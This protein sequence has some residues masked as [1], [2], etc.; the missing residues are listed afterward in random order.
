MEERLRLIVDA[1]TN[2]AEASFG[3]LTSSAEKTA[4]AA[5]AAAASVASAADRVAQAR[6]RE[7]D[8]AGKLAIAEAKLD[9][10]RSRYGE[11]S[12]QLVAAEERVASAQRGVQLAAANTAQ[13]LEAQQTAQESATAAAEGGAEASDAAGGGAERF[14]EEVDGLKESVVGLV[15]GVSL[16]DWLSESVSGYLEGARAAS[17][18]AM[19]MNATTEEG[20]RFIAVA[21]QLGLEMG[22]LLEIQASFA[23]VVD[24]TPELLASFGAEVKT[25]A[26]GTTNWALTLQDALG[27]LQEIPDATQRNALGF[28]LFGEEGYKQMSRLLLSGKSVDEV[29][30]AMG[31]PFTDEDVAATAEFESA[32]S[33]LSSTGGGLSREVGAVLVP[34]LTAALNVFGAVADVVT[35]I[36]GPMGVAVVAAIA[37]AIANRLTA[38]SGGLLAATST[39][40]SGALGRMAG[41]SMV[42][43]GSTTALGIAGGA[44][45]LA[46]GGLVTMLGGP[47]GVALIALG[48]GF[49]LLNSTMGDS[50][51]ESEDAAAAQD[52]L[53]SALEESGGVVTANVRQKAALSAQES[54]LLETAKAAGVAQGDVTDALLGNEDALGRVRSAL[55]AYRTENSR[56]N[57][58]G[59]TQLNAQ[60]QAA[61]D[62]LGSLTS[63][64]EGTKET[65][66]QQ[67]ELAGELEESTDKTALAQAAMDAL[68]GALDGGNVS[69]A[70]LARLTGEAARAQDEESAASDRAKAALDAYNATTRDAVDATLER[71]NAMYSAEDANFRFLDAMDEANKATDDGTTSVNEQREA[72]VKLIQAVLSAAGSVAD[73][74][75]EG[76]EAAGQVLTD[77][78]R[79]NVRATAMIQDLRNKMNTPG[80]S[81]GAREEIQALIDQLTTAQ[82][83]GDV[84]A[85]LTLTGA[86]EAQHQIDETTKDQTATVTVESRGGP[87]VNEYLATITN[88]TRLAI[89]RVESRNGPAVAEY[90]GGL[91]TA[92]RLSLIRVESRNGPAVR[93]YLDGLAAERLSIIRVETRGGPAVAAYLDRLAGDR[94]ARINVSHGAGATYGAP[95]LA[96][97]QLGRVAVGSVTLDLELTGRA[98]RGQLTKAERG[99]ARVEEIRA[100]ERESGRGWRQ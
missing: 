12:S 56:E 18:L 60:G 24:A 39:A 74:A 11:G 20:G 97:A 49:A 27:R 3:K 73:A 67:G 7:A 26:D 55:E 75:I 99:R 70:D 37:L 15:A 53:T 86:P 92:D 65:A 96:G 88:A 68:T 72:Q 21:S 32:M 64:A 23:Q 62:A 66:D 85:V 42:A 1:T 52:A 79:A 57:N 8:A 82:S 54:G 80:M 69:A 71:I 98:D 17:S 36:P 93:E 22:D 25:N 31:T 46:M 33:D 40:A 48:A 51:A 81:K 13:A 47:L 100:Y 50:A 41:A 44:T 78:D 19:S 5:D 45:R 14:K 90:L 30:Q 34:M 61:D 2:G 28:Q 29:F 84:Q 89:V 6:N 59:T 95:S 10:A 9:E 77:V 87:A 76:R 91:A 94:S 43:A 16:A 38:E 4:T 63:L 35:A 58:Y 83:K